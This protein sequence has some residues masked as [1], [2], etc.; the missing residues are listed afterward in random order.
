M[1]FITWIMGFI[2]WDT[3]LECKKEEETDQNTPHLEPISFTM[4]VK[5]GRKT[6]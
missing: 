5:V 4:N 3:L 1:D 2:L 6:P